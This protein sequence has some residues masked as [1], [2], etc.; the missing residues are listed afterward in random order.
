ML[1]K[2]PPCTK[3]GLF[4]SVWT[5]FGCIASFSSTAG[6]PDTFL[7][8]PNGSFARPTINGFDPAEDGLSLAYPLN[9]GEQVIYQ[10][11][12][13]NTVVLIEST[14]GSETSTVEIAFLNGV[15]GAPINTVETWNQIYV[16]GYSITYPGTSGQMDVFTFIN[17]SSFEG[18]PIITGFDPAQDVIDLSN[19]LAASASGPGP[20]DA[21]VIAV[22]RT[23]LIVQLIDPASNNPDNLSYT[24]VYAAAPGDP[25]GGEVT[26]GVDVATGSLAFYTSQFADLADGES[27]ELIFNYAGDPAM[28]AATT[29]I[30]IT[31]TSDPLM[32]Q[33]TLADGTAGERID[34]MLQISYDESG[35]EFVDLA[36]LQ[37]IS[38]DP[39]NVYVGGTEDADQTIVGTSDDDYIMGGNG[40]D[41]LSGGEGA[42]TL[43]GNAGSD[44]FVLDDTAFTGTDTITDYVIGED[45]VDLSAL[46]E[47]TGA[48]AANLGDYV[49]LTAG[50]SETQLSLDQDAA[51]GTANEVIA[52]FTNA[53]MT[54]NVIFDEA[55]QAVAINATV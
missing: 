27:I 33:I 53:A 14:G 28:P 9:S 25:Y 7:L 51:P 24:A 17:P 30:T 54:V 41:T 32:P 40:N 39:V 13:S 16:D 48:N 21:Q 22:A 45:F 6:E 11:D 4:S 35:S 50:A 23:A 26:Y 1:A 37:G 18:V 42:D 38:G 31:G 55:E 44:V 8:D 49:K 19:V 34:T 5:R 47:G 52:T 36:V 2:G 20:V 15:T 46:L 10:D 12:G 29:L 43:T 3:A